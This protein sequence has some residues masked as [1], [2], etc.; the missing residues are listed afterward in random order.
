MLCSFPVIN[1]FTDKS[2]ANKKPF[3]SKCMAF[4]DT[5]AHQPPQC[6]NVNALLC[7]II[8]KVQLFSF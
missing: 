3:S 1:P 4:G 2:T 5:I 7:F 8:Y 6:F